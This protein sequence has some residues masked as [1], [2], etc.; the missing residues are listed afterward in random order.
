MIVIVGAVCLTATRCDTVTGPDGVLPAG[1]YRLTRPTDDTV[2]M[3]PAPAPLTGCVRLT[4]ARLVID[5]NGAVEHTR[6]LTQVQTGETITQEFHPRLEQRDSSIDLV[7]NPGRFAVFEQR[8]P[9]STN[10][11]LTA[12]YVDEWFP[13]NATCAGALVRL[14]YAPV[15]TGS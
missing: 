10:P 11:D 4:D 8:E 1:D 12:L 7:Y 13:R 15:G 6:T 3:V 14:R 9:T 5:E 2:L